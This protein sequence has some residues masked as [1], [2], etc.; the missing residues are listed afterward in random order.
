MPLLPVGRRDGRVHTRGL[1]P[2]AHPLVEEELHLPGEVLDLL[3]VRA[4]LRHQLLALARHGL[5][6]LPPELQ[7]PRE[8][9]ELGDHLVVGFGDQILLPPLLGQQRRLLPDLLGEPGGG[10][11]VCVLGV[12][13]VSMRGLIRSLGDG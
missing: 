12:C 13:W 7:V 10:R 4:L 11:C 2:G 8:A 9:V 3:V 6:L 5:Q 1:G